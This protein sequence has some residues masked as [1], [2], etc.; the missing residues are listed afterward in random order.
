MS[1]KHMVFL[2]LSFI[3]FAFFFIYETAFEN[4]VCRITV[5]TE[6]VVRKLRE[7]VYKN[8]VAC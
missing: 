7:N 1:L 8:K 5:G 2:Y 4:F 6:T 3:A